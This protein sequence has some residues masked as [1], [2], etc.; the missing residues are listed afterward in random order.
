MSY[1]IKVRMVGKKKWSFL[2]R[3][4]TNPLRIHAAQFAT[5]EKAQTL[6]DDN[7]EENPEWEWRIVDFK[8][9]KPA[10]AAIGGS[11]AGND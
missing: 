3:R 8:T 11:D 2:T 1:A 4:G 10:R 6:I 7:R 5:P 9:G